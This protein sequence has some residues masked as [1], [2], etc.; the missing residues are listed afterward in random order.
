[1]LGPVLESAW[2]GAGR[3][4]K[5]RHLLAPEG[6]PQRTELGFPCGD[7]L[8]HQ[9]KGP[10][11]PER[12]DCLIPQLLISAPKSLRRGSGKRPG[13]ATSGTPAPLSAQ[14]STPAPTQPR[15]PPSAHGAL[16]VARLSVP[17]LGVKPRHPP[18]PGSEFLQEKTCQH[19]RSQSWGC[20]G[21][22]GRLSRPQT[23][24]PLRAAVSPP[25]KCA[26]GT[27]DA[28]SELKWKVHFL[29]A[30]LHPHPVASRCRRTPAHP[31]YPSQ[32]RAHI[33]DHCGEPR[34][35]GDADDRPVAASSSLSGAGVT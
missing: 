12:W 22:E 21:L 10:R 33:L 16:H 6:T 20:P 29:G 31:P 35:P 17:K 9:I 14:L 24:P 3:G 2:D 19:S 26:R 11:Y 5:G 1:M 18:Q 7:L 23:C 8:L 25:G 15:T 13:R 30:P 28:V 4:G 27:E 32:L 34:R